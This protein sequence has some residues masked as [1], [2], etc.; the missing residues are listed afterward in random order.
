MEAA[1]Q[2]DVPTVLGRVRVSVAGNPE[3]AAMLLW[4]SLLM[5]HTLWRAQVAHFAGRYRTIAVD[6][7]GHGASEALGR[8]FTFAECADTIRD[9]LDALHI[10]RAHII[11]NSWGA[12]IGGTF[13]A[14]YPQ[15]VLRCVLMNGTASPAPRRQQVEYA[16]LV[17]LGKL[18]GGFRG[19]LVGSTVKAFLGP[20]SRR[21]RPDVVRHV[22]A[23]ARRNDVR[24][25]AWA[26]RSVVPRRPDQRSL[27]ATIR[28]PVLVIAGRE[29]A[30]FPVAEVR[31]HAAAIPGSEFALIEDAAHLVALEVPERVNA[32]LDQFLAA[33]AG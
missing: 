21:D 1:T 22:I 27:L 9:L 4:P 32:L 6:P 18:I 12:M 26:I 16:A 31:A 14:R 33:P 30:T 17:R 5:D 7:P 2:V 13:A 25:V 20:T 3:G 23:S 24:S 10:E 19:P 11:G 8:N 15:R 29:D 28:T